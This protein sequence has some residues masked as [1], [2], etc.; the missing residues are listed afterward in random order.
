MHLF[1]FCFSMMFWLILVNI[2]MISKCGMW[3]FGER[4]KKKRQK[5]GIKKKLAIIPK[6]KLPISY[7]PLSNQKWFPPKI[8]LI[9][10]MRV[11][12]ICCCCNYPSRSTKLRENNGIPSNDIASRQLI[13]PTQTFDFKNI[14]VHRSIFRKVHHQMH[15][16][17][18]NVNSIVYHR[19]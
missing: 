17:H 6:H 1:G 8:P 2:Y 10:W 16:G 9:N 4:T 13:Q 11:N 3:K 18:S 15:S 7:S 12:W 5:M 14:Q 19:I